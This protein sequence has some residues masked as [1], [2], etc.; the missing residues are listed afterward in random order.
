[1]TVQDDLYASAWDHAAAMAVRSITS[2]I[3]DLREL[4]PLLLDQ[5]DIADLRLAHSQLT[6]FLS[7]LSRPA[8]RSA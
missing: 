1:M 4:D 2:G 8:K 3:A 5:C 7:Q 6:T